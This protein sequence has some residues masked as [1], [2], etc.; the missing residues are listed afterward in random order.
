VS[1]IETM[2]SR[3]TLGSI[4]ADA[5][6]HRLHELDGVVLK[7]AGCRLQPTDASHVDLIAKALCLTI[8]EGHKLSRESNVHRILNDDV[9]V[10]LPPHIR[11]RCT[12]HRSCVL[13]AWCLVV[14]VL[15][16]CRLAPCNVGPCGH[17]LSYAK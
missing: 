4:F 7:R 3:D 11:Q 13:H 12:E 2:P 16:P 8:A 9:L 5:L 6:Q 17:H 1:L 15:R 10:R 14:R